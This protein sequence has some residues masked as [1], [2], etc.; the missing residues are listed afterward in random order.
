MKKKKI[1]YDKNNVY[2]GSLKDGLLSY[3]NFIIDEKLFRVTTGLEVEK[4]KVLYEYLDPRE[5]CQNIEYHE[6]AKDK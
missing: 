2:A 1:I 3:D 6:P 4:F 5:N